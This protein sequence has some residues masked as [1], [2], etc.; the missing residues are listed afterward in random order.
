MEILSLTNEGCDIVPRYTV[1]LPRGDGK[2][3]GGG[4]G[5]LIQ[6]EGTED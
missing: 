5:D 6:T 2:G 3:G 4:G 1:S